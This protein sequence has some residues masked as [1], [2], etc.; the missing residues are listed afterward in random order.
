MRIR[1]LV[2]I[3]GSALLVSVAI[4]LWYTTDSKPKGAD[5]HLQ[6]RAFA[7]NLDPQTL[8]DTE[9]RK[10]ATLL[11]TGLVAVDQDGAILPRVAKSWRRRDARTWEFKLGED[12]TFSDGTPVT[13]AK[14][15]SSLC[16]SMQPSDVQSWSLGSIERKSNG[17]GGPVTCT[18]LIAE[19]RDTVLIREATP[20]PWLF[21]ALAG[22]GGWIIDTDLS[23]KAVYGVRPGTGPY[24]I[25]SIVADQR[26]V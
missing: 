16:A 8:A 1:S 26:I 3:L 14:V 11:Y 10:V 7:L 12:E 25:S 22:P 9:S 24:V 5:I 20:T 13:P 17:A 4:A 6:I 15:I 21:E 18:G 19:G 23:K 2:I